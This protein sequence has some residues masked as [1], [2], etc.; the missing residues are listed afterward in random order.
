MVTG[1]L[2]ITEKNKTIYLF[3]YERERE[4]ERER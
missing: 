1:L 3:G 4:R 2:V